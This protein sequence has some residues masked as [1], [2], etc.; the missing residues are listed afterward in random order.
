VIY[1]TSL[2][3]DEMGHEDFWAFS[4]SG[5]ASGR[6]LV[7]AEGADGSTAQGV[8]EIVS[9]DPRL[10]IEPPYGPAGTEYSI[11]LLYFE[12]GEVVD[13]EIVFAETGE[14]ILGTSLTVGGVRERGVDAADR[15][16]SSAYHVTSEP[17]D[18]SGLYLVIAQ[19]QDGSTARGQFE[20]SGE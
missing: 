19:G 6:Y 12:P 10:I 16:G 9:A 7:I 3:V 8:F 2:T 4:E 5:D 17:G 18:A 15:V 1:S 20:V 11:S 13:L 14:T